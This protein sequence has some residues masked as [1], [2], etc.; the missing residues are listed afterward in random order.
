MRTNDDSNEL[1]VLDEADI[2]PA[3]FF[4]LIEK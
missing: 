4:H 2:S 1:P 3:P